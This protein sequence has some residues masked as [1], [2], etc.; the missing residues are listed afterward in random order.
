MATYEKNVHDD[1]ICS[2]RCLCLLFLYCYVS[3]EDFIQFVSV[4]MTRS[5]VLL[6]CHLITVCYR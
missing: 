6:C 3:A 4:K 1:A 2:V 5:F